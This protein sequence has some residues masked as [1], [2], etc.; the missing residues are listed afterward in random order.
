MTIDEQIAILNAI[1]QGKKI[2]ARKKT[3]EYECWFE[4]TTDSLNFADFDYRI[5][6]EPRRFTVFLWEGGMYARPYNAHI[7]NNATLICT[8]TEDTNLGEAA[9]PY[10]EAL[11][12]K[13]SRP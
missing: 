13:I 7:P 2:E 4:I 12:E 3:L 11:K 10:I 1:K 8:A 9:A 6:P 5:V